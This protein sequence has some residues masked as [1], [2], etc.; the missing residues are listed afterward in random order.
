MTLNYD[1]RLEDGNVAQVQTG[2]SVAGAPNV[3]TNAAATAPATTQTLQVTVR[4][5]RS[6]TITWMG[7]MG[8]AQSGG[9]T[10]PVTDVV[11]LVPLLDGAALP[12]GSVSGEA[13]APIGHACSMALP[14]S[15]VTGLVPGSVHTIA[16]Q[17]S[18]FTTPANT[19]LLPAAGVAGIQWWSP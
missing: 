1:V 5:G 19:F 8:V 3:A 10:A 12:A 13:A 7:Q 18:D 6:G 17:A 11:E 2:A 15:M 16:I 14:A 4:V 9:S